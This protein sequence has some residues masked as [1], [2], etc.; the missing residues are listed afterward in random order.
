MKQLAEVGPHG[1][2]LMDYA[3]F[4]ACRAGFDKVVFV[5]SA[6]TEDA[7]RAHAEN[8][9]A[10]ALEVRYA[11]Q[12][13][14]DRRKPWGTGHAVLSA[15]TS[16]H[17]PFGVVNA[18][19]YYGI[20]SFQM[21]SDA[22]RTPGEDHVLVGYA[23][24]ETLSEFGAVSRGL[25]RLDGDHLRSVTELHDVRRT[26]D[27]LTSRELAPPQLTGHEVVSTNLWGFRRSFFQSLADD[28]SAFR[29]DSGADDDAE[30]LIG[31]AVTSLIDRHGPA[32]KVL[33]TSDRFFGVTYRDDLPDVRKRLA[34]LIADSH[35]P[36]RLW[37]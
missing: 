20:H 24:G 8:G 28:F 19:D 23:L 25:C 2:A 35:Y 14:G 6:G 32:V 37:E 34:G 18:D 11:T 13:S 3:I 10:R 17:G 4:D 22:L 33:M 1:H 5:V 26:G 29:A 30:F 31:T 9:C 36:E 27:G 7:V 12:D 16:V 21:L 15:R